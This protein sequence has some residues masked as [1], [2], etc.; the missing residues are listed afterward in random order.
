MKAAVITIL[1][2]SVISVPVSAAIL[3]ADPSNLT[4]VFAAAKDGDTIKASGTFKSM[5]LQNRTFATRVTLDATDAVFAD[6]LTIKNVHG[7]NVLRGTFGSKTE[8]M[9]SLRSVSVQTSSNI[10]FQSNKF[11][12]TGAIGTRDADIGMTIRESKLVQVS[13]ANFSN[14]RLGIG[15]SSSNNIK[16]GSNKFVAMTSDGINIANSHRVT[17]TSN[18]CSGTSIFLGAH[19][20]CIQLWSV[21]GQPVQSDIALIRNVATGATQGFTSFNPQDGGGLRISMIGNIVSTTFPQGIACY[22]CVDSTFTDNVI[23]T[24]LEAKWR[25][26][27]HIKYGTNNFIANNSIGQKPGSIPGPGVS[28]R[29]LA[30]GA[31][32]S[33]MSLAGGIANDVTGV[34]EPSE[35]LLLTIGF[36]LVGYFNRRPQMTLQRRSA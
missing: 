24:P 23:T 3:S 4:K 30:S 8:M 36:G 15:V 11:I 19:P 7:L 22:N 1:L 18:N 33:R 20:D 5:A 29:T 6:T 34:P 17:A 12:G 31:S 25:T 32:L 26:M 13:G 9:R 2:A 10:K 16:L 21:L 35:W 28:L 14:L 27:M